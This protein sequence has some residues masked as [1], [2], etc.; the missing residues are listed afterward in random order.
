MGAL[1]GAKKVRHLYDLFPR[2][3]IFGKNFPLVLAMVILFHHTA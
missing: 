2:G 1:D 3:V